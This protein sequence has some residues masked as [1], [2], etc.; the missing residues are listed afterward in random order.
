MA[1][2]PVRRIV[3]ANML[4]ACGFIRGIVRGQRC[5]G[6]RTGKQSMTGIVSMIVTRFNCQVGGRI[7]T[8]V[9]FG[10]GRG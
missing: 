9:R 2:N 4:L 8:I 10:T 5:C 6:T 1:W 7:R 3:P